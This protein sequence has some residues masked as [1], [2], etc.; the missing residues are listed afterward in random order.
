VNDLLELLVAEDLR[1][2]V[3]VGHSYAGF[4]V[5]E[6]ADRVPERIARIVLVDAWVGRDGESMESRAPDWFRGWINANTSG[7]LIAV[8]PAASVGVS[9]PSDVAWMESLLTP[10]PS[11]TFSDAT[12]LTGAVDGVEC[13]AIICSP[14]NG[15]PFAD[16]ARE[17]GWDPVEVAS[18]HDVMITAPEELSRLLTADFLLPEV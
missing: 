2:V 12:A 7:G 18:G 8:P 6:V 9:D 4:V 16:W 11:R 15:V 13:Q 5:R 17:F 14:G 1:D 3:L 10:Q